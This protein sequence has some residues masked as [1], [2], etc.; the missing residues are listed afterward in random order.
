[1]AGAKTTRGKGTEPATKAKT[2]AKAKA[3]TSVKMKALALVAAAEPVIT[4]DQRRAEQLLAEIGRRKARVAEEFYDIGEA[5][6]EL[7]HKR[8]YSALGHRSFGELLSARKVMSRSQAHKLIALVSALPRDKALALGSEKAALLVR[9]SG[10][11]PEADPPAWLLERGSLPGGKKVSEA[12]A[13]DL[14]LAATQARRKHAKLS[15][16]EMQAH[17]GA[18]AAQ[19]ALRK[20]G[21]KG[22][23]ASAVRRRDGMWLHIEIPAATAG[24]L[25]GGS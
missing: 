21:A 9:Y 15:P 1:M 24:V 3:S 5:L 4:A 25:L 7:S 23:V 6:R 13:R 12:S 18:R 17:K 14:Q 11:T 2:K 22:A 16:E 19:A 8:L 20:R 10:A